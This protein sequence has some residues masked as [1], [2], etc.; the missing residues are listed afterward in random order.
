MRIMTQEMEK[1]LLNFA[2]RAVQT[3]QL[4]GRGRPMP[5][6][7]SQRCGQ[8]GYDEA[9]ID[10]T[11]NVVGRIGQGKTILHFDSHIDTV[12]VDDAEL[13]AASAPFP[14]ASSTAS[15][16]DAVRST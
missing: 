13:L 6:S 9:F 15:C 3:P 1:R 4:F 2:V 16:G 8:L 11:G 5:R 7:C 12:R 10:E 14:A